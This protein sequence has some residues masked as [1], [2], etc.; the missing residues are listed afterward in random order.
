M[1]NIA[2]EALADLIT[3]LHTPEAIDTFNKLNGTSGSTDIDQ[4]IRSFESAVTPE[5]AIAACSDI[6]NLLI[7]AYR[8]SHENLKR[9]QILK[10][11]LFINLTNLVDIGLEEVRFQLKI[12]PNVA[13]NLEDL[14]KIAQACAIVAEYYSVNDQ[15]E[16]YIIWMKKTE[17]FIHEVGLATHLSYAALLE[18]K[19]SEISRRLTQKN[20]HGTIEECIALFNKALEIY[21]INGITLDGPDSSARHTQNSLCVAISK[22]ILSMVEKTDPITPELMEQVRVESAQAFKLLE[23]IEI[24]FLKPDVDVAELHASYYANLNIK[25]HVADPKR[26]SNMLSTRALIE[27]CNNEINDGVMMTLAKALESM[28]KEAI[29]QYSN[30]LNRKANFLVAYAAL[31][32]NY[33][34]NKKQDHA[35]QASLESIAEHDYVKLANKFFTYNLTQ[36]PE[37]ASRESYAAQDISKADQLMAEAVQLYVDSFISTRGNAG[38]TYGKVAEKFLLKIA[39]HPACQSNASAMNII[40]NALQGSLQTNPS[41]GAALTPGF[42]NAKMQAVV[43]DITELQVA[44]RPVPK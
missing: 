35:A 34:N 25:Q 8:V 5:E 31:I 43:T 11:G 36:D 42:A 32:Y 3:L 27:L 4:L 15:V 24:P 7:N 37:L 21:A 29:P 39:A 18:T 12:S 30:T 33:A 20:P 19:A 10:D 40:I 2:P 28:P 16:N 41:S 13:S 23:A 38:E 44:P 26:M 9:N 22:R 1:P 14:A 6:A 17:E